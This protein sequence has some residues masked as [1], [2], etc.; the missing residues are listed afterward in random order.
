MEFTLSKHATGTLREREIRLEWVA[1]ALN[2]PAS[3]EPDVDDRDLT[4]HCELFP[5][6]AIVSSE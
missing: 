5:S 4:Q 1:D 3:T 2:S 6:S